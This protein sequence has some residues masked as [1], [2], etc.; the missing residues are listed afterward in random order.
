MV[1]PKLHLDADTSMKALYHALLNKGHDVTR[2]PNEWIAADASDE[3]QLLKSTARGRCI[4]TFNIRD[5]LVLANHYDHHCGL[6]LAAQSRWTLSDL[7]FS[8]DRFLAD[9]NSHL[10]K[11]QVLWLNTWR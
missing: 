11:G 1:K 7:V 10:V 8:L 9:T 6:L 2:T 3:E 4:F 5:F